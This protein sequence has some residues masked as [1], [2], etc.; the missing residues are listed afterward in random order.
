MLLVGL[1]FGAATVF[2]HADVS[3]PPATGHIGAS[4]ARDSDS[5]HLIVDYVAANSPAALAGIKKGDWITAINGASTQGMSAAD[6]R[7]ATQGEVGSGVTWTVR[8]PG[9][10]ERQVSI[11]RKSIPDVYLSAAIAG[12][13]AAEF[14]MGYFYHHEPAPTHDLVKA[15]DWYRKA[16]E[17]GYALAQFTLGYLYVNGLIL[18]HDQGDSTAE[19]NPDM[20][21]SGERNLHQDYP[22]AFVWFSLAAAQDNPNAEYYLGMF[23]QHGHGVVQDDQKAFYWYDRAARHDI[24]YAQW[25]L[26]YLYENGVGV[27]RNTGEALKWYARAQTALPQNTTLRAYIAL[28]SLRAF[29]E[30]PDSASLD[31]SLFV[32]AF[33]PQLMP[34]FYILLAAYVAGGVALFYFTVRQR[35]GPPGIFIAIGWLVFNL[36][37]QVIALA[38]VYLAGVLLTADNMF[39]ATCLFSALP[40]I[41]S[42]LGPNRKWMW[43]ASAFSGKTLLLYGA[44]SFAATVILLQ[45]YD[46]IYRLATHSAMP[47]QPTAV[48]IT[49]AKQGS[50]WLTYACVAVALP[51]AEEILFR[52]YLFDAL[53][54]RCPDA[55]VIIVTAFAFALVH[56][57]GLYFAPLFGFGLIQ[58][59]VKLRTGSL[60]LPVLLHML[61]NGLFLAL[62]S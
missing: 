4:L 8:Y 42:T 56:L 50:A 27:K 32:T 59:W 10:V 53:K 46:Q 18:P 24:A 51:M 49:K 23:Y 45:G 61:N 30:N 39:V 54:R 6:A 21:S 36:E 28:L 60:R 2:A 31:L 58:G 13:P 62:A 25:N 12:D 38:A 47:M 11:V 41:L 37:G 52:G 3:P 19:K 20:I 7:H 1:G 17:Q 14:Y 57:Q 22:N 34:L 33:R 16:A 5:G 55:L 15:V 40:V 9:S 48:M 44:G 43:K 26:A 35:E 29:V